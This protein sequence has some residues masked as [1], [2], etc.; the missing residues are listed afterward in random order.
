MRCRPVSLGHRLLLVV[1]FVLSVTP[2]GAQAAPVDAT[3]PLVD[4]A[5][6]SSQ[7][8]GGPAG[9]LHQAWAF[10]ASRDVTAALVV[11][12]RVFVWAEDLVAALDATTG[13][14][15]WSR[16]LGPS[17]GIVFSHGQL[18]VGLCRS[19]LVLALN[20][21]T[22]ANVWLTSIDTQ[23]CQGMVADDDHVVVQRPDRFST[24]DAATGAILWSAG[25]RDGPEDA[26]ISGGELFV[27]NDAASLDSG[28]DQYRS[29]TYAYD[30]DTGARRDVVVGNTGR[31]RTTT[32][33]G[34]KLFINDQVALGSAGYE[35][36]GAAVDP[37]T[38]AQVGGTYLT[39]D[40]PADD[41]HGIYLRNNATLSAFPAPGAPARWTLTRERLYGAPLTASGR[42]WIV[43][44]GAEVLGLEP[45]TGTI[46]QTLSL[47]D[48]PYVATPEILNAGGGLLLVSH[49][50]EV[51][52][53]EGDGAV[54]GA[55]PAATAPL[56]APT[57]PPDHGVTGERQD[58]ARSGLA[59]GAPA[60]PLA[61]R[62]RATTSEPPTG[63]PL[64]LDGAA[65]QISRNEQRDAVT[66]TAYDLADGAVRWRTA[67]DDPDGRAWTIA[68]E[69]GRIYAVKNQAVRAFSTADGHA[70]WRFDG[71][72][73]LEGSM[74]P[75]ALDGMLYVAWGSYTVGF[76]GATGAPRWTFGAGCY[77]AAAPA[78]DADSVYVEA[79]SSTTYRCMLTALDRRTG[80]R[81]WV[82][83]RSCWS[84][85]GITVGGGRVA[86]DGGVFDALTGRLVDTAH[87]SESGV[88]TAG[89]VLDE[90]DDDWAANSYDISSLSA[91]RPGGPDVWEVVGSSAP[92]L[93]GPYVFTTI[94]G[95]LTALR[96][97][98]GA[99]AWQA[100]PGPESSPYV[101]DAPRL[102]ASSGVILEQREGELVAWAGP[103]GHDDGATDPTPVESQEPAP[104]EEPT[105][106]D[107]I[108]SV[109][110]PAAKILHAGVAPALPAAR[111]S[112]GAPS[113]GTQTRLAT[114]RLTAAMAAA[115]LRRAAGR[116]VEV[117][118]VAPTT[119][120]LRI[121]LSRGRSV[122]ASGRTA[123]RRAGRRHLTLSL[124]AAGR[125]L[126]RTRRTVHVEVHVQL[127]ASSARCRLALRH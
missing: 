34:G 57:L 116:G 25:T 75:I 41:T 69:D 66:L 73:D 46:A 49:G 29:L 37:R 47:G 31:H 15:L 86:F 53:F 55:P 120:N 48:D 9:P 114:S 124:T 70:L 27:A 89:L 22:G 19:G 111:A 42:V 59:P 28:P 21:A 23:T 77:P 32:F 102:A 104:G 2:A 113:P 95:R 16:H 61:V 71:T 92:L 39:T 80:A 119:G 62:W 126:L 64:I 26:A 88:L 24:L 118:F 45:V 82:T 91:R 115:T 7:P 107:P 83:E 122:L 38:G 5:H 84:G 11:D 54:P 97:G 44:S 117:S 36:A 63:A 105:V 125:R 40:R 20:P 127:G 101:Q 74:P 68:G 12:G 121:T 94:G 110:V 67:V 13:R 50:D 43:A 90:H 76:D 106:T 96:V 3:N 87:G 30:L 35:T 85:G 99:L 98:D 81:R 72:A 10:D 65:I 108:V 14:R 112:S 51:I 17:G 56:T 8:F 1:L 18:V 93:S 79:V 52:A 33:H 58:A 100:P 109:P 6:S 123:I 103:A 4:A 60:P 78:A